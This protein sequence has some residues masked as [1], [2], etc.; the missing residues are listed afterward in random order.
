MEKHTLYHMSNFLNVSFLFHMDSMSYKRLFFAYFLK[1]NTF[2]RNI[3][4]LRFKYSLLN[5]LYSSLISHIFKVLPW[6]SCLHTLKPQIKERPKALLKHMQR[7]GGHEFT[8]SL[9]RYQ[10]MGFLV[11]VCKTLQNFH[12]YVILFI[13]L[14]NRIILV[15]EINL[16]R[17][18]LLVLLTHNY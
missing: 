13:E 12:V 14:R 15:S 16:V 6:Y 9:R 3:L 8:F 18:L 1:P 11:S 17:Q 5:Y 10:N 2:S 7:K 4:L